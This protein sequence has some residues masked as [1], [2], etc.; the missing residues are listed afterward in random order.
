MWTIKQK[1]KKKNDSLCS[2]FTLVCTA[3]YEDKHT[4]LSCMT[5]SLPL[6]VYNYSQPGLFGSDF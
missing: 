1:Q 6:V 2:V 5:L 4:I 3:W